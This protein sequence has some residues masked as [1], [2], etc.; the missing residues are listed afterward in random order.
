V[1]FASPLPSESDRLDGL[2]FEA[3]DPSG[4]PYVDKISNMR[5]SPFERTLFLD[6]DTFVVD[7]VTHLLQLLERYDLAV[8]HSPG[9][10]GLRDPEVPAA[11]YEFNTGVLAWRANERTDALLARWQ[12]TYLEWTRHEPF[13][14]A[15]LAKLTADQPAFRRSVWLSDVR[16]AVLGPEYNLRITKPATIVGPVRVLHGRHRDHESLARRINQGT[17][18]RNY[19]PPRR[20]LWRVLRRLR[21]L[22][23]ASPR[24]AST[25]EVRGGHLRRR[26]ERSGAR[27]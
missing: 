25:L 4:N 5:R 8:A 3:F 21:S 13:D 6:G 22:M 24:R 12:E 26:L 9:Y 1:V 11:F 14:D 19:A 23:K 16:V 15:G 10:R 17:G 2:V 18:A 7:E 20:V 27:R